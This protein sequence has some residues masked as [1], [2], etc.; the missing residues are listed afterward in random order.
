MFR[1]KIITLLLIL[2]GMPSILTGQTN[3]P[4]KATEPYIS[5]VIDGHEYADLG[6][7]SGT[8]WATSNVGAET[9]TDTGILV[10]W[11]ELEPKDEYIW[12][13]YKYFEELG[14][15]VKFD[16]NNIENIYESISKKRNIPFYQGE[17]DYERINSLVLNDIKSE[18]IK[19]ITFDKFDEKC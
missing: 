9:Y 12:E 6:L 15:N 7:P 1:L 8:L 17:P 14:Y 19:N 5:G 10:S 16:M 13:T 18:R 2:C 11:G 3:R 4:M